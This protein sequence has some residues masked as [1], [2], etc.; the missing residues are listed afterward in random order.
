M[1][2]ESRGTGAVQIKD[3]FWVVQRL[4]EVHRSP[5]RYISL[6]RKRNTEKTLCRAFVLLCACSGHK[7][8][9][10]SEC[11]IVKKRAKMV[12]YSVSYFLA[13]CTHLVE[14]MHSCWKENTNTHTHTDHV[15][16]KAHFWSKVASK[17]WTIDI[18]SLI[19]RMW[20][21]W[22]EE[23]S[24][25]QTWWSQIVKGMKQFCLLHFLITW[26]FWRTEWTKWVY[27]RTNLGTEWASKQG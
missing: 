17:L 15:S 8:Q 23:P 3:D 1:K 19:N 27:S 6:N 7:M 5:H 20:L 9:C 25:T 10:I 18:L 2:I 4:S 21:A 26:N 13:L 12:L 11:V 24:I 22:P 16:H 14:L